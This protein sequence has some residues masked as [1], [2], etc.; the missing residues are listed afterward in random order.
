MLEKEEGSTNA[1]T[2]SNGKR[3]EQHNK[4]RKEDIGVVERR[5]KSRPIGDECDR[6]TRA[7]G[8]LLIGPK[9]GALR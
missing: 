1:I 7:N 2:A 9:V 8:G 5:S 6:V 3:R 4:T